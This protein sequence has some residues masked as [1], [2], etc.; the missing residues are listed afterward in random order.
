MHP[1]VPPVKVIQKA[2]VDSQIVFEGFEGINVHRLGCDVIVPLH[3][4]L[5]AQLFLLGLELGF[6]R[7]EPFPF[8]NE[9]YCFAVF[10]F[11][12][13]V[14]DFVHHVH[15]VVAAFGE[16]DHA[17]IK[18]LVS[19]DISIWIQTD[20]SPSHLSA[21]CTAVSSPYVDVSSSDSSAFRFPN[22]ES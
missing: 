1:P 10:A 3:L 7:L 14:E 5:R 17:L 12:Y 16:L 4:Q 22:V 6:L 9:V 21:Y 13:C 11:R 19:C 20:P 18:I 8:F 2:S 15:G